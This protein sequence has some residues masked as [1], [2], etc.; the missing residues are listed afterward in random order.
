MPGA[1]AASKIASCIL[2]LVN[3]CITNDL[4]LVVALHTAFLFPHFKFLQDGDPKAD[5]MVSFLARC[6]TVRY[7][8]ML[9]DLASIEEDRWMTHTK[10]VEYS[11]ILTKLEEEE[12]IIQ[13]HKYSH[14]YQICDNVVRTL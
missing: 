6:M 4:L 5:G 14:L 11:K 3:N 2:N 8:F 10:F 7:H 13:T 12:Q 1:S 9:E